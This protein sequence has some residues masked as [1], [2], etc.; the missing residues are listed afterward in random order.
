MAV[1]E[2]SVERSGRLVRLRELTHSDVELLDVW[3][4]DPS[5]VGDFNDFGMASESLAE[6]LAEGRRFAA[7]D[8]GRLVVEGVGD[9]EVVGDMSWHPV[10]YGPNE[11]SRAFNFGISLHPDARGRG[12]GTEAQRMLAE[13]L[14]DLFDVERVEASTD[15]ENLPEQRSLEKA[16]FTREGVLRQAQHRRGAHHDLVVYSMVRTDLG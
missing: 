12:Y 8:L 10:R 13:L 16:G 11:G 6:A 3:R 2:E 1:S 9:G 14:F 4:A 5:I 7:E 15:V